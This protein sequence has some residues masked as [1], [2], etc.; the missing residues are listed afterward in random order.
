MLGYLYA[1]VYGMKVIRVRPFNMTGPRKT[2]DACSDFTRGLVEIEKGLKR[3]L[4]VG[5]LETVRDFTD[6]R[7]AVK[8]LW[9]IAQKGVAGEAYS[10]CSGKG[11]KMKEILNMAISLSGLE[12]VEVKQVPEKMRPYDDPIYIGDNSKL[13][14]LGWEPKISME[15]TLHD[16]LEYWR[17]NL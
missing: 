3:Y 6:G 12:K 11:Y 2:G 9:I 16:M 7:D 14:E 15:K 17:K 13:R 4:E 10:L 1:K 5:N 8:A